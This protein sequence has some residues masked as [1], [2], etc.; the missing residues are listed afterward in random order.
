MLVNAL[1]AVPP[2]RSPRSGTIVVMTFTFARSAATRAAAALVGLGLL[3]G[4]VVMGD[5]ISTSGRI[6]VTA[7]KQGQ[8]VILLHVCEVDVNRLGIATVPDPARPSTVP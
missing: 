3:S 1:W 2:A 5:D 7:D 4:C 8:L 6:G